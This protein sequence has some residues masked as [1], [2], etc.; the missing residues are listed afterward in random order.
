MNEKTESSCWHIH[1]G[2]NRSF[3]LL[4]QIPFHEFQILSSFLGGGWPFSANTKQAQQ[5][6]IFS[7]NS[8]FASLGE[9]CAG[10][11]NKASTKESCTY[12]T[13]STAHSAGRKY[14]PSSATY[15]IVVLSIE[16]P[17]LS[18]QRCCVA[19]LRFGVQVLKSEERWNS[20]HRE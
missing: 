14:W 3:F 20:H 7:N 6:S 8:F 1:V 5:D 12:L 15:W 13:I 9:S 19:L 2:N 16:G 18:S 10:N 4:S 11:N 17:V